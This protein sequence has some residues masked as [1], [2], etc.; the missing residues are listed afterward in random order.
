[1]TI[2]GVKHERFPPFIHEQPGVAPNGTSFLTDEGK[3]ISNRLAEAPSPPLD[4]SEDNCMSMTPVELPDRED[5]CSNTSHFVRSLNGKQMSLSS[6]SLDIESIKDGKKLSIS[7]HSSFEGSLYR[8]NATYKGRENASR[9]SDRVSALSKYLDTSQELQDLAESSLDDIRADSRCASCQTDITNESVELYKAIDKARPASLGLKP[10]LPISSCDSFSFKSPDKMTEIKQSNVPSKLSDK[11][12]TEVTTPFKLTS[13][14]TKS[15]SSKSGL[16]SATS[17]KRNTQSRTSDNTLSS[18][19]LFSTT[20]ESP[21]QSYQNT[22]SNYSKIRLFGEHI[23]SNKNMNATSDILCTHGTQTEISSLEVLFRAHDLPDQ[24]YPKSVKSGIYY[25][26]DSPLEPIEEK[27]E[28]TSAFGSAKDTS[29]DSDHVSE[30]NQVNPNL[31]I[32]SEKT[33]SSGWITIAEETIDGADKL[34]SMSNS[35]A[36]EY[37]SNPVYKLHNYDGY[38]PDID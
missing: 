27:A 21:I 22:E 19:S 38:E 15:P 10:I 9:L 37:K 13:K 34:D 29:G 3:E 6:V 31:R 16:F 2:E 23:S 36:E 8:T 26:S 18:F 14:R 4:K 1:M 33:S 7:K 30:N 35:S 24:M 25:I 12:Q 5:I 17:G 28:Q 11:S 20:S 32:Y